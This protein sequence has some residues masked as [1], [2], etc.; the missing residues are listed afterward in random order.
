[1]SRFLI[2]MFIITSAV[3]TIH[4]ASS[5]VRTQTQPISVTI[6][7]GDQRPQRQVLTTYAKG[8]TALEILKQVADVKIR[9]SGKFRFVTSIDGLKSIP[10]K[11]G[12][13]YS[14]DGESAKELA[15]TRRLVD[16]KTMT[17]SYRVE[18]CY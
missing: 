3:A 16:A 2:A 4:A 10:G 17:W 11:M 9:Q 18:A 15:A 1:M 7:Y 13:F 14:V 6:I 5:D 12:W 8:A